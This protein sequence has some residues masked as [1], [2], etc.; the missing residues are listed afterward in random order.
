MVI[1]KRISVRPREQR[2]SL[3]VFDRSCG[4]SLPLSESIKNE[5]KGWGSVIRS[6]FE[7][8]TGKLQGK[9]AATLGN[10]QIGLFDLVQLKYPEFMGVIGEHEQNRDSSMILEDG[11]LLIGEVEGAINLW[12]LGKRMCTLSLKADNG[13][14]QSVFQK[15]NIVFSGSKGAYLP[16]AV[17][18][19]D[20]EEGKLIWVSES[21]G[22]SELKDVEAA[23]KAWDITTGDLLWEYILDRKVWGEDFPTTLICIEEIL[24]LGYMSGKIDALNATNGDLVG[25][26]EGHSR[27][28]CS[29]L[30]LSQ[31]KLASSSSDGTIKIW[32][33][34]T[35]SCLNTQVGHFSI[36]VLRL[37]SNGNLLSCSWDGTIH[38]WDI[39]N[40][41]ALLTLDNHLGWESALFE[42]EG[43]KLAIA[44][45]GSMK[46][47]DLRTGEE[48]KTIKQYKSPVRH[49]F[50]ISKR[51]VFSASDNGEVVI[52]NR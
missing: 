25:S 16:G 19:A 3:S 14:I 1:S 17:H 41:N 7:I 28:I 51:R 32:D 46:V 44:S 37:L 45:N 33:L 13:P 6:I 23:V 15:G 50:P 10:G 20:V 34:Q 12:D 40:S 5:L 11:R 18:K 27:Y 21:T 39:T 30:P 26:L 9:F 38:V 31:G 49:F 47:W 35:R 36:T 8:E 43:D 48:C 29:L 2:L 52:Y 24:Y 22:Q 42:L 4:F